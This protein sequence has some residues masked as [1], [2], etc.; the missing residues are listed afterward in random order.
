MRNNEFKNFDN[1]A[2]ELLK[3]PHAEIKEKLDEEKARKKRK[4]SKK[5]SA[6]GHEANDRA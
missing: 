2:R 6:S 1:V 3:V 4:K 5:S